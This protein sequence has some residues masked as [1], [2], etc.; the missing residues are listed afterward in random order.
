M[1]V[2]EALDRLQSGRTTFVIAH[3]LSTVLEAD[4]ILVLDRGQIVD[5]GSHEELLLR[6]G[7][8]RRL[9]QLQFKIDEFPRAVFFTTDLDAR[10]L[11]LDQN[12]WTRN[13]VVASSMGLELTPCLQRDVPPFRGTYQTSAYLA[14][15]IAVHN[16]FPYEETGRVKWCPQYPEHLRLPPHTGEPLQGATDNDRKAKTRLKLS[17]ATVDKWLATP[18]LFEIGRTTPLAL[19]DTPPRNQ[20]AVGDIHPEAD[21]FVPSTPALLTGIVVFGLLMC[22][23]L[24]LRKVRARVVEAWEFTSDVVQGHRG[25]WGWRVVVVVVVLVL[26]ALEALLLFAYVESAQRAGEPFRWFEGLSIWPSEILRSIALGMTAVFLFAV[27]RHSEKNLR[28]IETRFALPD[29]SGTEKGWGALLRW[30]AQRREAKRKATAVPVDLEHKLRS[31]WCDYTVLSSPEAC[32]LRASLWAV[33]LLAV[34]IALMELLG[35][36][37]LPARGAAAARLDQFLILTLVPGFLILLLVVADLNRLCDRFCDRLDADWFWPEKTVQKILPAMAK[38]WAVDNPIGRRVIGVW[39][40]VQLLVERSKA[41]SPS[42]SVR[43][44]SAPAST[45]AFALAFMASLY[46]AAP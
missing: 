34:G 32:L 2:Q 45:S 16:A 43:L 8:Y 3:R 6:A 30:L 7:L 44:G 22:A 24:L 40:K 28:D 17:Q 42:G 13:V 38:A 15:R 41:V 19:L 37:N 4:Q 33:M 18:R 39:I 35:Y 25:P 31:Y 14:A 5:R 23:L 11:D 9:Y 36:P 1:L 20:E 27:C 26:V 29:C 21:P 46:P 12:E 10:M